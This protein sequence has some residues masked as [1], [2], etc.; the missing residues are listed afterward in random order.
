MNS[1]PK[2][3]A[4]AQPM[5][6]EIAALNKQKGELESE[7]EKALDS[8]ALIDKRLLQLVATDVK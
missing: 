3:T 8:I 2:T 4:T 1:D 5:Q 7:R 6:E